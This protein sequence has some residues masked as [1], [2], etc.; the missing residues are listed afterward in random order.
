MWKSRTECRR[1]AHKMFDTNNIDC[2][3]EGKKCNANI[4][5]TQTISLSPYITIALRLRCLE[6]EKMQMMQNFPW[7]CDMQSEVDTFPYTIH[8]VRTYMSTRVIEWCK[9]YVIWI[10]FHPKMHS[11]EINSISDVWLFSPSSSSFFFFNQQFIRLSTFSR[12]V[13]W[14]PF[15][16][17]AAFLCWDWNYII[18]RVQRPDFLS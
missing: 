5:S 3:N 18:S 17:F 1:S 8:I 11:F 6:P 10:T 16:A 12:F 9:Y 2:L 13:F 7:Y 15:H 14:N 4:F